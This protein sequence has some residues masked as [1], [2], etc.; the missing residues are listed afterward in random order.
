LLKLAEQF[1]E[2][3]FCEAEEIA[4][5]LLRH[6]GGEAKQGEDAALALVGVRPRGAAAAGPGV[7][8]AEQALEMHELSYDGSA[9]R[10][11]SHRGSLVEVVSG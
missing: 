2:G 8:A 7:V 6:L 11:R 4:E 10:C 5:V 3:L 9:V 1:A